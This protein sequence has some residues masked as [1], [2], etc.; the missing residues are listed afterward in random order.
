MAP[1]RALR[2]PA[3]APA[4]RRPAAR[5]REEAVEER[6]CFSVGVGELHSLGP[7]WLK[8][9][10][11]YGR[12]VDL[13]GKFLNLSL[14]E[15]QPMGTFEVSGTQDEALLRSLTGKADKRISVHLCPEGCPGTLTD[16]FMVHGR[17]F[18]KVD[19]E[20]SEAAPWFT[21]LVEVRAHRD[22]RDELAVLREDEAKRRRGHDRGVEVAPNEEVKDKRAAKKAKK[23]EEEI[24]A[25]KKRRSESEEEWE[26]GQKPPKLLFER[27]GLDPE[28]RQRRRFLRKARRIGR[29][30]KSKKKKSRSSASS[31]KSS[32]SSSASSEPVTTVGLFE[33]E[34]KL[35]VIWQKFPGAL[36]CSAA[37]EA[38]QHLLTA[39]GTV[40]GLDRRKVDPVFTHYTR[41]CLMGIMSP[42]MGQEALTVAQTLDLLLQGHAAR[43]CDLMAQR[44]KSLESSAR[45]SHWTVSRQL[46]LVKSDG[47]TIAEEA[48]SHEAAKRA[49][50]EEKLRALTGRAPGGRAAE[51]NPTTKGNRKG[52]DW[53]GASKGKSDESGRGKG[54]DKKEEHRPWQ[55]EKK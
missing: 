52:K 30:K 50:E 5:E 3:R 19:P 54:G 45:G 55:K 34:R 51:A 8:S 6:S 11:Y 47:G 31:S 27:T 24:Q 41:Q 12:T 26:V 10:G 44:L 17:F 29:S 18:V 43:A 23:R 35:G 32:S 22:E 9:A 21:N 37:A 16:E 15:G 2:R 33:S 39:S 28:G 40:W 13:V 1:K 20:D 36:A 53:K 49:R 42:P 46:E 38:K 7:V 14:E 4:L 25:K 48:E